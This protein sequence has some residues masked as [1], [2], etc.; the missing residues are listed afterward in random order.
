MRLG[1]ERG[2]LKGVSDR[3]G[4]FENNNNTGLSLFTIYDRVQS[5]VTEKLSNSELLS[6]VEAGSNENSNRVFLGSIEHSF[7]VLLVLL[8]ITS[9]GLATGQSMTN[10]TNQTLGN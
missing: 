6:N 1:K 2:G 3:A 9:L 10:N 5:K 8:A 7:L 4:H